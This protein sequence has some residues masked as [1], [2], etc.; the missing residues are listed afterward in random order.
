MFSK[1]LGEGNTQDCHVTLMA[2]NLV[3]LRPLRP[4]GLGYHARDHLMRENEEQ[5]PCR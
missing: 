1:A 3:S 5:S 2:E 4:H